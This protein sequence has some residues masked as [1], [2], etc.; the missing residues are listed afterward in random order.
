M[1]A[2]EVPDRQGAPIVAIDLGGG[3]A[4]SAAVAVWRS[5]RP[6]RGSVAVAPGLPGLDEQERR[7]RVPIKHLPAA[8]RDRACYVHGRGSPRYSPRSMLWDCRTGEMG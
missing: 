8:R 5:G 3:R 2:R 6:C 7:D 4:F 1:E